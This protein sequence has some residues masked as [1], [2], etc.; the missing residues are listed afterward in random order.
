MALNRFDL[1]GMALCALAIQAPAVLTGIVVLRRRPALSDP[2]WRLVALIGL[3]ALYVTAT[4]YA[5]AAQ[6]IGARHRRIDLCRCC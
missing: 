2:H 4:A 5:R 3:A 1:A 6:P